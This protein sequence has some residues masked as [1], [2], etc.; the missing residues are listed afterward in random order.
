M[1]CACFMYSRTADFDEPMIRDDGSIY[2]PSRDAA[3]G[4][5]HVALCHLASTRDHLYNAGAWGRGRGH[6]STEGREEMLHSEPAP[7]FQ[8]SSLSPALYLSGKGLLPFV[9]ADEFERALSSG[10]SADLH[11]LLDRVGLGHGMASCDEMAE[12]VATT[13][14]ARS[15]LVV[16]SGAR[17]PKTRLESLPYSHFPP[18]QA[19]WNLG[20]R[21]KG[22]D[23]CVVH[24][25]YLPSE[26]KESTLV[27]E[28]LWALRE[29][30]GDGEPRCDMPTLDRRFPAWH[31]GAR[32]RAR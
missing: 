12:H 27:K 5:R 29:G 30:S 25:N 21:E 26:M 20:R 4:W 24:A 23:P 14:E 8:R 10:N 2:S 32:E 6:D 28:G 31:Q 22:V 13:C 7:S 3:L 18:G 11:D 16:Q 15:E 9:G 19:F 1:P 17:R